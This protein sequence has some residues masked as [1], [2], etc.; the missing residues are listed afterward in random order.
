MVAL[1]PAPAQGTAAG[2]DIL[3]ALDE[4]NLARYAKAMT[5]VR[6]GIGC[7]TGTLMLGTVGDTQRM[8]G[9]AIG[10]VISLASHVEMCTKV[11]PECRDVAGKREVRIREMRDVDECIYL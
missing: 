4:Y 11:S 1:F 3:R 10:N 6:V 9:I 5:A 8:D 7:H 2:H